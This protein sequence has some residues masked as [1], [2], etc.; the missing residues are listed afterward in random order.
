MAPFRAYFRARS[1]RF[2]IEGA[3]LFGA[4]FLLLLA[5]FW[6]LAPGPSAPSWHDIPSL[7]A[8]TLIGFVVGSAVGTLGLAHARWHQDRQNELL[9]RRQERELTSPMSDDDLLLGKPEK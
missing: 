4:T 2:F 7:I 6:F 3:C 1:R 9:D 8:M 5:V